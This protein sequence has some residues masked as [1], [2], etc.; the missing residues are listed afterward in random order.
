MMNDIKNNRL[1][2]TVL[3]M[4][5]CFLSPAHADTGEEGID[6]QDIVFSH[7]QDAYTWHITEW[8]GKEIAIS[9][10]VLVRSEERGWDMFLSHHLHHG[11]AHHGY[12]IAPEGEHAGKVVEKN[13]RGEEVRPVDLSL[14]KNV[15]GLFLS[16]GILLF[17]VLRTARWYKKHPDQVPSGFT[18][19][20]EMIISYLQEGVIKDSIG[21]EKYKPFS[22][23][24]LT[25]FF[26]ILI[27][28]LIGIIPVFPGGANITGN[29]AVTAVL[30]G[31]TFIAVNLFATKEY[32]KEIFWPKAP[33]YLKLPL[34]I[35]P[36]V[37]FFGV[38]TKPFALMIRLFANIMAGHTIILALT[39]LIFITVSM[40]LLVN[41]GMTIVSVLF[42]AFMNCV[43]LFV[44]CL[45]AYIFTLLSANYI[46]MA[47]VEKESPC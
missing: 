37:E 18:G 3:L 19:L 36:F 44:A 26:F 15:C 38:F 17:V 42:C 25:V 23:Y 10:P 9:L 46:G 14:T 12:Y 33:I 16:C 40:G 30:A 1:I 8:N 45:Q 41:F 2:W 39:C 32:W 7:I 21:K 4:W 6:V 29:I 22:S 11:Q 34:P 20:M 13:S 31:C 24:L 35:M 28:N 43:E 47:K 5:I 27:N